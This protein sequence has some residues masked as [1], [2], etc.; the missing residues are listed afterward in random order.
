MRTA[1]AR[2][3]I[4]A[5]R[6]FDLI[7]KFALA[8]AWAEGDAAAIR[9][10]EEAYLE[11][12]RSRNGFWEDV[13]RRDKPEDFIGAFRRTAANIREHGY[14]MTK[15]PIPV[16]ENGEVLDGAHRISC[17]AAYGKQCAIETSAI[18]PAGGSVY[19]TF[20][21]G[22]IHPAVRNWGVRKYFEFFPD[23]RLAEDFGD[24]SA[25][26]PLP[27]PDWAVR[28]RRAWLYKIKPAL[29]WFW[30]AITLPLRKPGKRRE[31]IQRRMLRESKKI[32]GYAALAKY[33]KDFENK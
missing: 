6:R 8:K 33:W 23:G 25:Y 13:P 31:K 3:V 18:W 14:D 5:S 7:F 11:M 1:D 24:P 21:K 20:L 9:E 17:C 29:A 4:K 19:R 32:T 2:E 15:P 12:V 30:C 27:F 26:K 22:H 10:A 16:D 28:N